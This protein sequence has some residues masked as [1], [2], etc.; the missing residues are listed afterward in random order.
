MS[1]GVLPGLCN[2][3][4]SIDIQS[5]YIRKCLRRPQLCFHLH[6]GYT[7]SSLLRSGYT[8][9]QPWSL[10]CPQMWKD[11][12]SVVHFFVLKEIHRLCPRYSVVFITA[13]SLFFKSFTKRSASSQCSA[14][15]A[16]ISTFSERKGMLFFALRLLR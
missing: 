11:S 2:H 10:P 5:C 8:C 3:Q 9:W 6:R 13:T 16:L 12:E 4:L 7:L 1:H 14:F 15:T